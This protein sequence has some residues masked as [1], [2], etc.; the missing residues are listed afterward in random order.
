MEQLPKAITCNLLAL[1][2]IM[3]MKCVLSSSLAWGAMDKLMRPFGKLSSAVECGTAA[4]RPKCS[5]NVRDSRSRQEDN[6][7]IVHACSVSRSASR[8]GSHTVEAAASDAATHDNDSL[9]IKTK[10][11]STHCP[12]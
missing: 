6:G 2:L 7:H 11:V 1:E 3:S 8:V 10:Q 5:A 4:R 12:C 9:L